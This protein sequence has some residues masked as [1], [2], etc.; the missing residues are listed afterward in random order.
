[1]H[2]PIGRTGHITRIRLQRSRGF[3]IGHN[4]AFF[5]KLTPPA[6]TRATLYVHAIQ[7]QRRNSCCGSVE[8]T[9]SKFAEPIAAYGYGGTH[10]LLT[11]C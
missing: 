3:S 5:K 4:P 8:C 6:T 11:L 10:G 2:P 9:V 7:F 1:M